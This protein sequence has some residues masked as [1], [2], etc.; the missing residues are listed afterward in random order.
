MERDRVSAYE[1]CSTD[2]LIFPRRN[3]ELRDITWLSTVDDAQVQ[4][5]GNDEFGP[6]KSGAL[7]ITGPLGIFRINRY[8]GF[9]HIPRSGN[10]DDS[11]DLLV[12]GWWDTTDY[13][14]IFGKSGYTCLRKYPAYGGTEESQTEAN[15]LD[16]FYLP[17]RAVYTDTKTELLSGLLLLPTGKKE[18]QFRRVGIFETGTTF[19]DGPIH[20]FMGKTDI[21][22]SRFFKRKR[23][24]TIC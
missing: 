15:L 22:D 14:R 17:I 2:M 5:S 3:N 1:K 4:P 23:P 24:T 21:F 13:T 6:I 10:L 11:K 12:D 18:G 9:Q 8:G 19:G 20:E 16:V 7:T